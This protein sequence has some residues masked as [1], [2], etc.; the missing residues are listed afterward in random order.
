MPQVPLPWLCFSTPHRNRHQCFPQRPRSMPARCALPKKWGRSYR[1]KCFEAQN[2]HSG[3]TATSVQAKAQSPPLRPQSHK[4]QKCHIGPGGKIRG[5]GERAA[6][7]L[8][9]PDQAVS[10]TPRKAGSSSARPVPSATQVN[11]SSATV[12]GK[13]VS[14]RRTSSSPCSKAPPPVRTMP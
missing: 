11:G 5:A 7:Y 8:A 12:T 9:V 6:P 2:D 3:Q 10:K 4:R 13:P 1:P 14:S